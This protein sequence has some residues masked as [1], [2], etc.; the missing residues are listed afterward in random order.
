ML[1]CLFALLCLRIKKKENY[2]HRRRRRRVAG[3]GSDNGSCLCST[4][5]R[6]RT[7]FMNGYENMIIFFRFEFY[8]KKRMLNFKPCFVQLVAASKNTRKNTTKFHIMFHFQFSFSHVIICTQLVAV[9]V[10]THTY[11]DN[12][13][14]M[15]EVCV[16]VCAQQ[17]SNS[18]HAMYK[19]INQN[20]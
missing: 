9:M 2:V 4:F 1:V 19:S 16:C 3:A 7:Y 15:F 18:I 13:V 20:K 10:H 12:F 5:Y 14:Y 8:G 6:M 11:S 17:A